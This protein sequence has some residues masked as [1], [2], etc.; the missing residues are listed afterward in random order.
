MT[1]K[2]TV[3][4]GS[5]SYDIL[6]GEDII[7]E[8]GS[9]INALL[10]R[11]RTVIVTDENVA[12]HQLSRLESNL[13]AENIAFDTIVLPAGEATKSIGQLEKLLETMLSMKLERSDMVIA[14]GGGVIG[15]LVGFAASIYLRGIDFI[16]VPTTL[17]AQVDSSVGGKTGINSPHGKNLIGAFH[18]PRLVLIDV[19]TLDTLDPRHVI[20]GYAEIV[21]YGL[22]NDPEFFKWLEQNGKDLISGPAERSRALRTEA[23]FKSCEAK[24]AVVAEDEKE[25]GARALLNLGHTFGHALEAENGYN[26]RLFHGEAV[27]MGIILAFQLSEKM[28]L[29]PASDVARVKRHFEQTSAQSL[30]DFNLDVNHLL[31]HMTKDKKMADGKL[32]F[33]VASGIGKSYL[34]K[35]VDMEDVKSVLEMGLKG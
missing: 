9:Y 15:D 31:E 17:L 23:I 19:T 12:R 18:Q 25:S 4:L 13:K 14:L 34:S 24:A 2:T 32:T 29:C 26:D 33:V 35:D 27:A 3:D 6:I 8:A 11:P 16:Q 28:G 5:R 10:K 20:A 1:Q 22:I 21:K 7:D 30:S